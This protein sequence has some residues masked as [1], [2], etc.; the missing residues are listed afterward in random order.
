MANHYWGCSKFADWLR[1]TPSGEAKSG[2]EWAKWT[3][4]AKA[5]HPVR[6]WLAD[7][8]IDFVESIVF[9]IPDK[10]HE[11]KYYINNRYVTKSHALS[12]HPRNIRPG[13]W[14][15]VGDRFL[16]CLFNELQNF[17][18]IEKAW[19][20]IAW[21]NEARKKYKPPFYATGWL[22]WRTWRSKA[23]GLDH[24]IWEASLVHG[25]DWVEPENPLYGQPTPQAIAAKE[26]MELYQWW[27]E[28]YPNRPDPYDV[29]KWSEICDRR[30]A[31]TSEE[32][33]WW[34]DD[35]TDEERDESKKSLDIMRDIEERYRQEDTEMLIRLI[36]L[37]D[38]LWT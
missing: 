18:E 36:N 17:V 34:M 9:Y 13:T 26:V 6:Y 24:L 33:F 20:H 28:V 38:S 19:K 14:C 11:I 27:T 35:Q 29:S 21:D 25:D 4:D 31:N 23:A 5:K 15:D 16:P 2:K 8:G 7:K 1:G 3:K 32:N 10:I 22:R 30:R 37:R 12:A